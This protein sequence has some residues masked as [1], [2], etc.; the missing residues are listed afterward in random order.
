MQGCKRL[1]DGVQEKVKNAGQESEKDDKEKDED[2]SGEENQRDKVGGSQKNDQE[3]HEEESFDPG[4]KGPNSVA[5]VHQ[6]KT[7]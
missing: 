4:Q 1:N 2:E 6:E 3:D 7:S 5:F